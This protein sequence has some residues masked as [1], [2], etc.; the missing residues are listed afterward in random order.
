MI[1]STP[2]AD[3]FVVLPAV[4]ISGGSGV[5]PVIVAPRCRPRAGRRTGVGEVGGGSPVIVPVPP[6][7]S[8]AIVAV[9]TTS[10]AP[11][12]GR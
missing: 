5:C 11:E 7:G 3:A 9:S 2:E 8:F 12:A 6:A 4:M 1:A 10:G